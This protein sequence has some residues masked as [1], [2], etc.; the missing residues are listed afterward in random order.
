[1]SAKVITLFPPAEPPVDPD[2]TLEQGL[3]LYQEVQEAVRPWSDSCLIS[4]LANPYASAA[5]RDAILAELAARGPR[6]PRGF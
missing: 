3:R 4:A 1:M 5:D 6:K 2:M